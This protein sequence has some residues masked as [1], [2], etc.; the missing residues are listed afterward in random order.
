MC[1]AAHAYVGLGRIVFASSSAQYA[2]WMDEYGIKQGGV[3]PLPINQV[4][5][6]IAVD[7]PVPEL[8]QEV[9]ALHVARWSR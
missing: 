2:S 5:P 7:G 4:A 1:S 9:K 3:N 6:N 8:D